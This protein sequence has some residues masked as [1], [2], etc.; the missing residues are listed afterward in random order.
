VGSG[1]ELFSSAGSR[2]LSIWVA[3]WL[4]PVLVVDV[5]QVRGRDMRRVPPQHRQLG[6]RRQLLSR[7]K[8]QLQPNFQS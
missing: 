6:S 2:R 5:Q 1:Q 3:G 7:V 4:Q 8:G